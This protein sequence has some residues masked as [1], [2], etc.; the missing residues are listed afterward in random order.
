MTSI[1][2]LSDP[3]SGLVRYVGK[4][5]QPNRRFTNHLCSK[6]KTYTC[7]WIQ[8]LNKV[9]LKP[10]LE[11]LEE[12]MDNEWPEREAYWI[13]QLR[14]WGFNLTNHLASGSGKP[15]FKNKIPWNKG[16][17]LSIE[18][19]QKMSLTH[20][21]RDHSYKIGKKQSPERIEKRI[22][23]CSGPDHTNS[24]LS[25]EQVL[26]IRNSTETKAILARNYNVVIR[27]IYKVLAKETYKRL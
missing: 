3:I 12:C 8:S 7:N 2:T 18:T 15:K 6:G 5:N 25:R 23:K 10:V 26:E 9:G 16:K 14:Q 19:R 24:K 20:K 21:Q 4:S 22:S 1:Y 17:T 13:E 27:T 11:I